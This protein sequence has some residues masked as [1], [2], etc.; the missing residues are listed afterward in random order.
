MIS[1]HTAQRLSQ[2]NSEVTLTRADKRFLKKCEKEID[3]EILA[4]CDINEQSVFIKNLWVIDK[5]YLFSVDKNS[6][7]YL[8]YKKRFDLFLA[9]LNKY[10]IQGYKVS[11]TSATYNKYDDYNNYLFFCHRLRGVIT[12]LEIK[13]DKDYNPLSFTKDKTDNLIEKYEK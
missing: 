6:K 4:A 11:Y 9:L 3:N 12:N 10:E 5:G 1:L 2:E 7:K 13:W 8:K